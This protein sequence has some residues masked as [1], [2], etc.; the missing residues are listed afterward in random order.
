[1]CF[2]IVDEDDGGASLQPST[3]S[4]VE[5]RELHERALQLESEHQPDLLPLKAYSAWTKVLA[6]HFSKV[7]EACWAAFRVA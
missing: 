5:S 3:G 6:R 4:A 7:A 1:L 2:W